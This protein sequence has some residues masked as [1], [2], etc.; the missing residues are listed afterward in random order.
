MVMQ[1]HYYSF[2]FEKGYFKVY[3]T[4]AVETKLYN[5]QLINT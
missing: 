4:K 5:I 1:D 2:I 3:C